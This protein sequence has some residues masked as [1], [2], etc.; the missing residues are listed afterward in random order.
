ME[1]P[2]GMRDGVLKLRA[3]DLLVKAVQWY[4]RRQAGLNKKEIQVDDHRWVFLQ[5]G[6]G[7]TI[8]FVH[9]FGSEKIS[10]GFSQRSPFYELIIRPQALGRA[11]ALTPMVY[12]EPG[13]AAELFVEILIQPSSL[14]IPRGYTPAIVRASTKSKSLASGVLPVSDP[15][16]KPGRGSSIGRKDPSLYHRA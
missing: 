1:P 10:G 11:R 8:L 7:E 5:G 16:G 6:K 2:K 3:T 15:R 9:G 13:P 12:I 14:G 4:I